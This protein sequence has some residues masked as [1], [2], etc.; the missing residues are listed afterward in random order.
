MK[1]EIANFFFSHSKNFHKTLY[2]TFLFQYERKKKIVV[3]YTFKDSFKFFI[4]SSMIIF[5]ND[6]YYALENK[7]HSKLPKQIKNRLEQILNTYNK[8]L[9]ELEKE[10]LSILDLKNVEEYNGWKVDNYLKTKFK[11]QRKSLI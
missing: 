1:S 11:L 6:L 5:S 4:W 3:K 7:K 9:E 10:V 8:S 2:L